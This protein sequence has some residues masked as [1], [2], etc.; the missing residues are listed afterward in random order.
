M[1]R[2]IMEQLVAWKDKEPRKPLLVTGV[3]Q[4]GKTYILEAFGE[5][6]FHNY[7]H[8]DF[9]RQKNLASLFEYDLDV[10][11]ILSELETLVVGE[12]I[13]PGETL[14]IFD[15]IQACP[16]AIT[17]LKYFCEDMPEL[18][19]VAAGSLLGVALGDLGVSF[20]VGKVERIEM[21]PMTFKEFVWA[22]DGEKKIQA[23]SELPFSREIPEL[24]LVPLKK[25]YT[26]Y[27]I[28]G[29]MPEAVNV[30][31]E[32]KNYEAVEA[33]QKTILEDFASD[34]SKHAPPKDV[35]KIRWI[36]DSIPVQLAK[37]NNKFVFSH[38]KAGKRAADLEDALLWLKN[39]GLIYPLTMVEHPEQPL[40]AFED[41]TYFKVFLCDVGLLRTRA[42][43]SY[44]TILEGEQSYPVFK[45]AMAENFVLTEL[46]ALRF[47]PY[48][49]RSGNT[50]EVDFL[51]EQKG[52]IIPVE[53]KSADNTRAKSLTQFCKRYTPSVAVKLSLKNQ[54][55]HFIDTTEVYSIPLF[56]IEKIKKLTE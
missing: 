42:G 17:S 18:H 40:S 54:G 36:W 6:Q 53:T 11:R 56:A 55:V 27:L 9:D 14:L 21:Y 10:H 26:D 49:W 33:V 23:V 3:R 19:V 8:L 52:R 13:T 28:V 51:I 50:A 39:A 41:S 37:E 47:H 32:T 1:K 2:A 12:K 44:Q 22:I 5:E 29:G 20:P 48:F 15:E 4:C 25:M 24:L 7:V 34:F 38:A 45:G 31:L 35:P 46:L 43:L 30:F 16:N